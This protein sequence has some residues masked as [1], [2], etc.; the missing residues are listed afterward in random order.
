MFTKQNVLKWCNPFIYQSWIQGT[1][2]AA[3]FEDKK[4]EN[5]ALFISKLLAHLSGT[6]ALKVDLSSMKAR[7]KY[8]NITVWSFT[9]FYAKFIGYI[10]YWFDKRCKPVPLLHR[11][12]NGFFVA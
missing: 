2:I 5:R 7:D 10:Y 1:I 8:T 11:I 12:S 9:D 3:K 6:T 4:Y